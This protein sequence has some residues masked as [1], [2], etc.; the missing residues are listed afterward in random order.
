MDANIIGGI[1]LGVSQGLEKGLQNAYQINRQGTLDRLAIQKMAEDSQF[2][3]QAMGMQQ[4]QYEVQMQKMQ[5]DLD[6]MKKAKL[7]E[8]TY[9]AL[10]GYMTDGNPRWI[11]Q[12]LTESPEL[13]KMF[14]NVVRVE[15]LNPNSQ[16]DLRIFQEAGGISFEDPTVRKRYVKTISADGNVSLTDMFGI[17][18]YTGAFKTW[19]DEQFKQR[20]QEADIAE[21]NAKAAYYRDKGAGGTGEKTAMQKNADYLGNI[22][23]A[24]K[25]DYLRKEAGWAPTTTTKELNEVDKA[26]AS[27]L[28]EN[29]KFFE[30][31]YQPGT[32][33]YRKMEPN[34]QKIENNLGI[35]LTSADKKEMAD[36]K[37]IITLGEVSKG[38][39]PE[40]TGIIDNLVGNIKK[41]VSDDAPSEAKN[42]YSQMM[43][44]IRN[45]LYGATLPAAEMTSFTQAFGSLY[46]QDKA[47]KSALK[48]ALEATKAKMETFT[49]VGDEAVTHFRYGVGSAK[50]S[51]IIENLD[52]MIAT[53]DGKQG[54]KGNIK[55]NIPLPSKSAASNTSEDYKMPPPASTPKYNEGQRA[56]LKDG[57]IVVYSNGKWVAE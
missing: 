26:R 44:T 38:L 30:T 46:Q 47:V 37:R 39:T 18:Q 53:V 29:P 25:D 9:N 40:D 22:D 57:T 13:K 43:T 32:D 56:K 15:P 10:N 12:A 3:Q 35:K 34:I 23:P 42:A 16:D 21:T 45:G 6:S 54:S 55:P 31:V 50:L 33:E 8:T 11:N 5:M 7:K 48:T 24:L 20:K 27:V 14:G 36:I 41:Y 19:T 51:K 28:K 1:G 4:N 49:D 17:A 52:T 2:K